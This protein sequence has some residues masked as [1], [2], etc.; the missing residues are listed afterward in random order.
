MFVPTGAVHLIGAEA[1]TN[2]LCANNEFLQSITTVPMGDF[3]H[4]TLKI[5]FSL[6]KDTDINQMNLLK[7]ISEQTWC[8]SVEKSLTPNKVIFV[9]TKGQI[10]IARK[11]TDDVPPTFTNNTLQTK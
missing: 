2:L 11:W 10:Q 5:P 8:I 6:D 3:Q 4:E 1:Y 9:T 7:L